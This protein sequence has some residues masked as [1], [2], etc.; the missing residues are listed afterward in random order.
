VS[1]LT[2]LYARTILE[3]ERRPANHGKLAGANRSAA[4]ENPLC[5]DRVTIE[6][7]VEDG[8]VRE[9]AFE[10]VGCALSKASASMMTLAVAGKTAAEIERTRAAFDA[11]VVGKLGEREA[12][13]LGELRA[14]AGVQRFPSR[15]RCARLPWEALRTAL[16]RG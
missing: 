6:L 10:G 14:F 9:A 15:A 12:S 8:V 16:E 13:E 5:G 3:H 7:R 1:D 4:G 11:L 2:D